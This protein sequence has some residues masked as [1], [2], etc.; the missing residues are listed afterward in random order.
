MSAVVY[1][2][3][4][5]QGVRIDRSWQLVEYNWV[6]R[7]F[8]FVFFMTLAFVSYSALVAE[9]GPSLTVHIVLLTFTLLGA[10]FILEVHRKKIWFNSDYLHYQSTFGR[11]LSIPISDVVSCRISGGEEYE[12]VCRSGLRISISKYM[13]GG[14]QLFVFLRR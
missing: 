11:R 13:S 5:Y 9:P 8:S 14:F 1:F 4:V 7:I 6:A 2:A 10:L 3:F 12:I